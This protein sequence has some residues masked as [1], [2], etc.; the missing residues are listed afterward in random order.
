MIFTPEF[1]LNYGL[2]GLDE[3]HTRLDWEGRAY[4]NIFYDYTNRV[5]SS[6]FRMSLCFS[7]CF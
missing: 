3:Q 5:S 2:L 4:M 1:I 6:E 7:V